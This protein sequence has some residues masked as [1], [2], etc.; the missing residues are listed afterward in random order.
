MISNPSEQSG[1]GPNPTNSGNVAPEIAPVVSVVPHYFSNHTISLTNILKVSTC[2]CM[3]TFIGKLYNMLLGSL[4]DV[5]YSTYIF[6]LL[7]GDKTWHTQY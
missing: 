1:S 3:I 6:E 4:T 7:G 5:K 2:R